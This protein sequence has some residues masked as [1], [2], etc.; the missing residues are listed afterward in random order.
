MNGALNCYTFLSPRN[1]YQAIH[2]EPLK[3]SAGTLLQSDL[4]C[5]L[6][7]NNTFL[8]SVALQQV[9][10]FDF[11]FSISVLLL[12]LDKNYYRKQDPLPL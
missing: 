4:T 1:Y 11:F 12:Y 3:H 6:L 8:Y 2:S 7:Q 9:F 5:F 10:S